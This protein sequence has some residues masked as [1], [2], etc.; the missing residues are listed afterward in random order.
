MSKK[1]DKKGLDVELHP[2]LLSDNLKIVK[3]LYSGHANP[4]L[5]NMPTGGKKRM[6]LDKEGAPQPKKTIK[7]ERLFEV[8]KQEMH[9]WDQKFYKNNEYE[10]RGKYLTDYSAMKIDEDSEDESEEE[11]DLPSVRFI[12]HPRLIDVERIHVEEKPES[13]GEIVIG[14]QEYLLLP[15]SERMKLK[16]QYRRKQ[17]MEKYR[18]VATGEISKSVLNNDKLSVKKIQNVLMNDKS[19]EDPTK[20]ELEVKKKAEERKA[21]HELVNQQRKEESMKKKQEQDLDGAMIECRVFEIH[22][23]SNPKIRFQINTMAKQMKLYGCCVRLRTDI[24][25]GKGIIILLTYKKTHLNKFE[26]K[27][28]KY[29]EIYNDDAKNFQIE[30]KWTS[31]LSTS[32]KQIESVVNRKI[33]FMREFKDEDDLKKELNKHGLI[34]FWNL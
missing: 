32:S 15:K 13:T 2:S 33:W 30:T 11:E 26:N 18:K 7:H 4:Y 5:A 28:N 21:A 19:I 25:R 31:S 27:M 29:K 23:L 16:R 22:N 8:D 3:T 17:R 34:K 24:S 20:F 6:M 12:Q 10:I 1:N 14:S 9:P